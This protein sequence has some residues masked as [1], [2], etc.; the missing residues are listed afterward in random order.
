[1]S[2]EAWRSRLL[3][4]ACSRLLP[5]ALFFCLFDAQALIRPPLVVDFVLLLTALSSGPAQSLLV[6]WRVILTDIGVPFRQELSLR[7]YLSTAKQRLEWQVR[8]IPIPNGVDPQRPSVCTP[9]QPERA[10][11]ALDNQPHSNQPQ[12]FG[13]HQVI[14][15][16]VFFPCCLFGRNLSVRFVLYP[17][18]SSVN[19]RAG[20]LSNLG[21]GLSIS[22]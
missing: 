20:A 7:Q 13:R 6:E 15:V 3:T 18:V 1:M 12:G 2:T 10:E 4:A 8:S 11:A 5:C 9:Q 17:V 21:L 22:V 16:L 19:Q 14:G